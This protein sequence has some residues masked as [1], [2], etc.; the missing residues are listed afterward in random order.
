M[1]FCSILLAGCIQDNI[2]RHFGPGI[3]DL[4]VLVLRPLAQFHLCPR[5]STTPGAAMPGPDRSKKGIKDRSRT[6]PRGPPP[7]AVPLASKAVY[8]GAPRGDVLGKAAASAPGPGALNMRMLWVLF[9]PI[10][11]GC[12][13]I[14]SQTCSHFLFVSAVLF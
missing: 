11:F 12:V 8:V 9:F 1:M 2:H 7:K 4:P 6:P 10:A 13:P 14:F 3:V 5:L